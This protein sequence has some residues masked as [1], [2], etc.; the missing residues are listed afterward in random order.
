MFFKVPLRIV[1]IGASHLDIGAEP[2]HHL[3]L[4]LCFQHIRRV[5]GQRIHGDEANHISH[6]KLGIFLMGQLYRLRAGDELMVQRLKTHLR[7]IRKIQDG[8]SI[9]LHGPQRHHIPHRHGSRINL[10][11]GQPVFHLILVPFKDSAA[12]VQEIPDT[13][14]AFPAVAFLH[15]SIWHLVM[16]NCH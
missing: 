6:L 10:I 12:V 3:H 14:P 1:R 8:S 15:Q 16:G 13:F 11:K 5:A 9:S 4:L 7:I 2:V